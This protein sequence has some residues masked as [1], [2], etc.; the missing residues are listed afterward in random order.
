MKTIKHISF[1]V[2]NTL[3]KPNK[4]FSIARNEMIAGVMELPV[5]T[6][7]EQYNETKTHLDR[8]AR[9]H[10]LGC[11]TPQAWH[12]LIERVAVF[13]PDFNQWNS[14]ILVRTLFGG[15]FDRFV[16]H[17]PIVDVKTIESVR[18]LRSV[19]ITLSIASNS[20][21]LPGGVMQSFLEQTFGEHVFAFYVFSDEAGVAK[22]SFQ[23]F[24]Q[25]KDQLTVPVSE[26]L[27]VGDDP[28]YD[29]ACETFGIRFAHVDERHTVPWLTDRIL[30]N[31]Y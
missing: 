22:P 19:G 23:F 8:L 4:Q 9:E 1:D 5:D 6:V 24:R 25:V 30:A 16:K 29:K 26:T 12:Q 28:L 7:R 11:S 15:T 20:N 17:L 27:H 2:W 14:D 21:F 18:K 31:K 3:V 10:G 13:N